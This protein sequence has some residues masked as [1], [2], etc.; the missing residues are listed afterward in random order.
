M[1]IPARLTRFDLTPL[2]ITPFGSDYVQ[3]PARDLRGAPVF[4]T[5]HGTSQAGGANFANSTMAAY[6]SSSCIHGGGV[7]PLAIQAKAFLDVQAAA[8]GW[9]FGFVQLMRTA[10]LDA[11][12]RGADRTEGSILAVY[13]SAAERS[14]LHTD[15]TSRANPTDP[16]YDSGTTSE[17]TAASPRLL[18]VPFGDRPEQTVPLRLLNSTTHAVNFLTHVFFRYEFTTVLAAQDPAGGTVEAIT[19]FD[20]MVDWNYNFTRSPGDQWSVSAAGSQGKVVDPASPQNLNRHRNIAQLFATS[21]LRMPPA[22]GERT[23]PV[24]ITPFANWQ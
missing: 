11:A 7:D 20:W 22:L 16:W 15:R 18:A 23:E 14:L 9:T 13:Y 5:V 6:L 19:S 4:I 1:T 24:S 17:I 3:A 2:G 21:P 10:W 8:H 12:Y